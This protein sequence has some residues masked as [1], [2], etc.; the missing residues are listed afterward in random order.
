MDRCHDRF[1]RMSQMPTDS[2]D[3]LTAQLQDVVDDVSELL[4]APTVLE[5]T[6]FTLLAYASHDLDVDPVRAA[7]ILRKTAT[8]QVRAYFL[9]HGIGTAT[10]PIHIPADADQQIL[11]RTCLPARSEGRTYGYLWVLEPGAR[12]DAARLARAAPLA[13]RAGVLLARRYQHTDDHQQLIEDLLGL[14]PDVAERGAAALVDRGDL[15]DG[16]PLVVSVIR[17]PAALVRT[18]VS[19]LGSEPSLRPGGRSGSALGDGALDL[20]SIRRKVSRLV[21]AAGRAGLS[22]PRPWAAPLRPARHEADCAARVALGRHAFGPVLN[23]ADLGFYRVVA[24]GPTAVEELI[25]GTPAVLLRARAEPELVRTALVY[26]D[27]AGH[28]A[29]TAAALSVH[30]QTLYYRLEKI[31]QLCGVDLNQGEARLQLHIGL[32]LGEVLP[33]LR[34]T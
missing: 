26:L 5:D 32:A 14:D 13:E 2:S 31:E 6:A 8:A 22:A 10:G 11:A 17:T 28:A 29:R 1:R 21:P 15:V 24:A 33:F 7:S 19:S 12:I 20:S 27:E 18:Q 23:W 3:R 9:E 25:A 16:A 30:R 4:S 34:E